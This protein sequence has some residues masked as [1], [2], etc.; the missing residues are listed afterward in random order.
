MKT[1]VIASRD[2]GTWLAEHL[3]CTLYNEGSQAGSGIVTKVNEVQDVWERVIVLDG[4]NYP[5]LTLLTP[6]DLIAVSPLATKF[7]ND[8]TYAVTLLEAEGLRAATSTIPALECGVMGWWQ[9]GE[10]Q[11]KQCLAIEQNGFMNR[12][13]GLHLP[14]AQGVTVL[15][16]P[17]S[18]SL[19]SS[20]L[21]KLDNLLKDHYT[22]PVC[23]RLSLLGKDIR[24]R[25]LKLGFLPGWFE[26]V[27]EIQHPNSNLLDM[28]LN[29]T[30]NMAVGILVSVP[31]YPYHDIDQVTQGTVITRLEPGAAR[32]LR[33]L[34]VKK[35]NE[36]YRCVGNTGRM[37]YATAWGSAEASSKEA[38]MRIYRSLRGIGL[39]N[40][41]YRTDVNTTSGVVIEQ[42]EALKLL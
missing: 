32:H 25:F 3:G 8:Y 12:D 10:W 24:V 35:D 28:P 37:F 38:R 11:G 27:L 2:N 16:I 15:G 41:Q 18:S 14:E 22:G 30:D 17:S 23:L 40:I 36:H 9:D 29:I 4:N 33:W 13:L 21:F 5:S 7:N 31:P 34:D 19:L 6:Q 26:T 39:D 20:T 1:L 42:L